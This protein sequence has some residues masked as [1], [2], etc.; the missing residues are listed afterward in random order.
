MRFVV[1]LGEEENVGRKVNAMWKIKKM[2]LPKFNSPEK[3]RGYKMR[4]IKM[5]ITVINRNSNCIRCVSFPA[6]T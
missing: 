2:E 6:G 1:F 5:A 3:H 4:A